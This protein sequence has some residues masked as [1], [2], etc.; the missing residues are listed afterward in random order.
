MV[1]SGRSSSHPLEPYTPLASE[2]VAA[3]RPA[4]SQPRPP[5]FVR[6]MPGFFRPFIAWKN[7]STNATVSSRSGR[8]TVTLTSADTPSPTCARP[9]ASDG[10]LAETRRRGNREVVPTVLEETDVPLSRRP[11]L[12]N[13][14]FPHSHTPYGG[15]A[16]GS[17]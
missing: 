4:S 6:I 17:A 12:A 14:I 16:G 7:R 11:E 1:R 13:T 3:D 9:T 5:C 8:S 2:S 10:N 15:E